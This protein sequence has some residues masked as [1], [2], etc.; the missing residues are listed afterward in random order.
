V[1]L[2]GAILMSFSSGMLAEVVQKGPLA[3]KNVLPV[4]HADVTVAESPMA[5]MMVIKHA[6]ANYDK[7]ARFDA[8]LQTTM[9]AGIPA[10]ALVELDN[11]DQLD[12]VEEVVGQR[13]IRLPV[14]GTT[15]D[16]L[17]ENE[18]KLYILVDGRALLVEGLDFEK[19]LSELTSRRQSAT[20]SGR[21]DAATSAP[22]LLPAK[23]PLYVNQRYEFSVRWPP[24]W[25]YRVARNNDGA[26]GVAPP[27]SGLEARVWAA[28]EIKSNDPS[29]PPAYVQIKDYLNFL[30][31]QARGEIRVESKLKVF[32]GDIEGRDYTYSYERAGN[33]VKPDQKYRGR[34]QAFVVDGVA[35][36][37]CVEGPEEEFRREENT[38]DKFIYSFHPSID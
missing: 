29:D 36:L 6:P 19:L 16:L 14:F 31:T 37:I 32:D 10:F 33:G 2:L 4:G 21:S 5:A 27:G 35:K 3:G 15:E 38:V 30:K 11:E 13:G 1:W 26:V 9:T 20:E 25:N 24:G 18:A 17:G 34:I 7:L 12:V 22:A 8:A 28:P 23:N